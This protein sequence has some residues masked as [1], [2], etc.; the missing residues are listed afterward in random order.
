MRDSSKAN[1]SV[2]FTSG[3]L[4]SGDDIGVAYEFDPTDPDPSENGFSTVALQEDGTDGFTLAHEIGHNLGAG[5]DA[6]DNDGP[7]V[8]PYA[9]GYHFIGENGRLYQDVM[10]YSNGTVLPFF[11][12]P[13]FDWEGRT[14]RQREA[15]RQRPHSPG[16]CPGGGEV[17]VRLPPI[18]TA[19][20]KRRARPAG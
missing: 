9:Y 15:C 4:T 7:G 13:Y 14:D 11:S 3:D 19:V 12:T 20:G 1:L 2:L 18:N 8:T 6:P 10:D 16:G 17:P 5:H